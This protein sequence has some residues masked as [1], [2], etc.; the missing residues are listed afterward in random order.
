MSAIQNRAENIDPLQMPVQTFRIANVPVLQTLSPDFVVHKQPTDQQA[1]GVQ[2]LPTPGH[3]VS[4]LDHAGKDEVLGGEAA[5]VGHL[6]R[7]QQLSFR[8]PPCP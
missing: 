2:C 6:E 8:H 1:V 3:L 5:V 7:Q 4:R